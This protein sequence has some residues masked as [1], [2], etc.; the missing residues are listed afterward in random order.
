[1]AAFLSSKLYQNLP[2]IAIALDEG[3]ASTSNTYSVFYGERLPWWV[4]ITAQGN[5]G[6]GSRFIE[7]TAVEQLV[8]LMNKALAFRKGQRDLLHGEEHSHANNCSHS[9]ALRNK[10]KANIQGEAKLGD[11]TSLNITHIEAGVR[12]RVAD[13]F[14][15]NC[16]PP[17]AKCAFDILT[18]V[19]HH[20]FH[21]LKSN[22]CWT[23]GVRNVPWK[24]RNPNV[25]Y[26]GNSSKDKV[27]PMMV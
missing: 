24:A 12:V 13:T 25:V 19:F 2:G 23:H 15:Y 10:S 9:V 20:M 6:H 21:P 22:I 1:M 5:T 8:D 4:S 18:F 26:L 3:L 11:V 7:G 17:V 27:D 14:A 16:V